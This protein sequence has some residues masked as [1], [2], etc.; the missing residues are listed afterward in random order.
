MSDM[1]NDAPEF[2]PDFPFYHEVNRRA[3]EARNLRYDRHRNC[4][5]D[6]EGYMIR[7]RYGQLY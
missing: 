3:A 1:S 6:E 5:V 2:D 4:Y 7:D